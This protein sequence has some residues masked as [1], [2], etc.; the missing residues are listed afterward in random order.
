MAA[1]QG[2]ELVG[3][4]RLVGR[5][6]A[7]V[8][9]QELDHVVALIHAVL[10]ERI[11][12]Q[13]ANDMDARRGCLEGGGQDREGFPVR[14]SEFD[15]AAFHEGTRRG[16]THAGD[17]PVAT[18]R[19]LPVARVE[20]QFVAAHFGRGGF[21]AD[22]DATVAG[23]LVQ[24]LDV[25]GLGLREI[26]AAVQHGYDIALFGIGGEAQRV[27]NPRIAGADNRDMFVD[28]FARIVELVLHVGLIGPGAAHQVGVALG[29]DG[30]DHRLCPDRF[31]LAQM[32][33]EIALGALDLRD[34]GM[35]LDVNLGPGAFTVPGAQYGFALAGIEAEVRAQ[36]QRGRGGHDV[37]A[38]L[39]LE[40]RVRQVIGLFQQHVRN[41][42]R[43]RTRCGA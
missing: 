36:H 37:L 42:K 20:Q 17:N 16:R 10:D 8:A 39:V 4:H 41:A 5:F 11:A 21:G 23:R 35:V 12:R 19:L 32:Q 1:G 31:P 6:E 25:G 18:D 13:R 33:S 7:G 9:V 38:L 27:F 29:A 26:D 24:Q 14:A 3:Q 22:G 2:G 30:E 43:G 28:V 34:L 40:D 15:A